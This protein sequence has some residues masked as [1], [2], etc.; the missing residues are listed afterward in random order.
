MS[1]RNPVRIKA[2][3]ALLGEKSCAGR[4]M[5]ASLIGYRAD[6]VLQVGLYSTTKRSCRM[7]RAE[8]P[9]ISK[10]NPVGSRLIMGA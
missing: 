1:C 2:I 4:D 5:P 10:T 6:V 7:D 9:Q 3:N 8:P